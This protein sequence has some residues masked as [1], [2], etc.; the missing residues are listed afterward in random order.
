[1]A[2]R[3]LGCGCAPA[4]LFALG[5]DAMPIHAMRVFA[6]VPG[7]MADDIVAIGI[8]GREDVDCAIRAIRLE[9]SRG[10]PDMDGDRRA[11]PA[12]PC[13]QVAVPGASL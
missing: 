6:T 1:M 8:D 7:R 12:K 13:L 5:L 10:D 3:V 11:G 2:D 4:G 9:R